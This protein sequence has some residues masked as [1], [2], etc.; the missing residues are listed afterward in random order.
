MPSSQASRP[1]AL[2]GS[3]R[4]HQYT[5]PA[6]AGPTTDAYAGG[7]PHGSFLARSA[8]AYHWA[9]LRFTLA[10]ASL[11]LGLR[12]GRPIDA[13]NQ[14]ATATPVVPKLV[15]SITRTCRPDTSGIIAAI[16]A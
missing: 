14:A 15:G 1:P 6:D 2:A 3:G 11:D 16:M 7:A 9:A 5:I 10:L 12:L 4:P 8:P 13:C